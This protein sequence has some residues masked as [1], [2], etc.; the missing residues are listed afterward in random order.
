MRSSLYLLAALGVVLLALAGPA[1]A[2]TAVTFTTVASGLSS[3][4]GLEPVPGD[5]TRLVVVQQGGALRVIENGALLTTPALN[6]SSS[7]LSGG[8]RGL[9]GLAFHPAWPDSAYIYVNYTRSGDGYNVVTRYTRSQASPL[10]FNP[11]SARVMVV[12]QDPFSNHNGGQTTFGP[13]G[14]LY[15]SFG[16]G[17]SGGDPN[18]S[19]QNLADILGSIIRIDVDGGGV[20]PNCGNLVGGPANYTV[21]A[22]NPF[23]GSTT[24]ACN[25]IY[26]YGMRNT[27]RFSFD[28]L[29]GQLWAADVGQGQYEEIDT[30]QAG[31]NYGWNV[32]E[33]NHCYSASTC[34][35]TGL[36]LPVFEYTH[37][38]GRCSI[39]GGYVYRGTRIPGLV[40]KYVYADYCSGQVWSLDVSGATDVNTQLGTR[41]LPTSFGQDLAGELYVMAG[42]VLYRIDPSTTAA[43]TAPGA[44]VRFALAGPSPAA[45][46]TAFRFSTATAGPVRLVLLDALGREV[47]RAFDGTAAADVQ[48]E[49]AVDVSALAPGV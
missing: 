2:Q 35:Q 41:S 17:G 47:A 29:N 48:Q 15:V 45:A 5:P 3:P 37:G 1:R 6:I 25:E 9:L 19:G 7:I 12:V 21:P 22:D 16:D 13:D 43:E 46:R 10:T 32:M 23:V 33:G 20:A 26:T 34:N 4:V 24:G 27:W 44:A 39:T 40:G 42:S 11:A 28:R 8:E 31:G 38:G 49:A 18:G 14:Y 30:L 36:K